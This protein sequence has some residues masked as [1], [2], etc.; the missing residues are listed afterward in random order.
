YVG[1]DGKVLAVIALA[2][3][4]KADSKETVD[5]LHSLGLNVVMLTGDNSKTAKAI[6]KQVGID[7]VISDVL[8]DQKAQAILDLKE[9]GRNVAMVGDGINDAPALASSDV[10]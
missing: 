5:K 1:Q 6:A 7:Q 4:V 8:P 9:K 2:D 3:Q 10:G